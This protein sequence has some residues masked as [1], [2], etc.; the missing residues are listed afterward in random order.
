MP[1]HR[2]KRNFTAGELSP[3]MDARIANDRY[4]NG[5]K[6]MQN[7][8]AHVQ[9][10]TTRRSGFQFI[11]DITSLIGDIQTDVTPRLVP[12]IYDEEQAYMMVFYKDTGGLTRVVW[13]YEDGLVEDPLAPGNPYTFEFTSALDIEK[14]KYVQSAD[15]LFIVQPDYTPIEFRRLAHDDWEANDIVFTERPFLTN[16]DEDIVMTP[17]GTTGSITLAT[18]VDLFTADFVGQL[19]KINNGI[20]LI[21]TVTDAQTASGTTQT[22]LDSTT[23][24]YDL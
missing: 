1:I 7:M 19:I 15:V 23:A 14:F 21:D 20:V 12:F 9:G 10:P 17:S 18:A 4:K 6:S 16:K 24:T 5:C 22:D 11:H 13:A 2:L 3:L 8:F